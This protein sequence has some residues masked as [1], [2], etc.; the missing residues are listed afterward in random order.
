MSAATELNL[1]LLRSVEK[2][3]ALYDRTDENYRKRLPSENAWDMVASEVGESVEKCKR[4]WRQLRNDYTRWC[5]ADVNR[6]RNGQRRLAYPLADELRFL[7]R[8]LNIADDMAADDDRSVL[9]DKD[10]DNNRDSEGGDHHSQALLKERAS[11]TSKLVKEVKLANQVRKEKSQDKRENFVN[12]GEKQ[13]S[14]RKSAE[15]KLDELEESDEPEK[16]PELDSF[17]QSDNEDDECMDEEHLDDLEGF[18]FDLEQSNQEKEFTPEK[19][20]EKNNTDSTVSRSEFFV[21]QN[22]DPRLLVIGRKNSTASFVE[23][24]A[25]NSNSG[26]PLENAMEDSGDEYGKYGEKRVTGSDTISPSRRLR[27][28]TRASISSA[29]IKDLPIQKPDQEQRV[30]RLQRRIS[31]SLAAVHRVRSSTSP[32]KMTPVPRSQ[33]ISKPPSGQ[34]QIR[35]VSHRD[36]IYPRPEVPA[37]VNIN[38]N[39]IKTQQQ[40]KP[41]IYPKTDAAIANPQGS[42]PPQRR[43]VGRPPKKLPVVQRIVSPETQTKPQS[44]INTKVLTVSKPTSSA[45]SGS[46]HISNIAIK[47][48]IVTSISNSTATTSTIAKGTT[49]NS[50]KT[51]ENVNV[52]SYSPNSST[53]SCSSK[54]NIPTSTTAGT[55]V[56]VGKGMTQ[57]KMAERS[58]QTGVPNPFS[59]NYFLEMI[60]PQMQE[61]NPR[62]KMHFKKKVF[63]A[64]MET[65]DDATDFPTS[66]ELQHFNIN[67]PSGFEHIT[68]PELRLVR[69]LVSMVSAAK[70]TLIRPPGEAT[71]IA[72]ASRSAI[73]PEAQRGA[74]PNVQRQVIQRAYKQGTGQEIV[75]TSPSGGLDKR[76]FRLAP[77][78]GKPNANLSVPQEML[79][80]DS[81]DSIHSAVKVANN[82]PTGSPKGAAIVAAVRPQGSLINKFFGQGNVPTTAKGAAS[83]KAYAISRRYSV[84][85]SSNPPNAQN[86]S[87]GSANGSPINS[88]SSGMDASMLKRR[89]IAPG[90]GMVPP[91]Q[92]PR[93][94]TVAASQVVTASQSGSLLVRKSVGCVPAYQKQISPTG[95]GSLLQKIPQIASVQGSA[96]ND[97]V[98]PKPAATPSVNGEESSPSSALKRSLVVAN[99]KTSFQDLLQQPSQT[100]QRNKI[101][102]SETAATIA[103]DDFSLENLKREPVDSA[104]DHNDILGI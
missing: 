81:V 99:T 9:S 92:R 69:E 15:E 62:Q 30:T 55:S 44:P 39:Q 101:E 37:V 67:T 20:S 2:Q 104:E 103:A 26:D 19:S 7:D 24:K 34:V 95:G 41:V 97:F 21:K 71:A 1:L 65:F 64:L 66:K 80:K 85:G 49:N 46:S 94:S 68:D 63:Q 83:E 61:M 47:S 79:R 27:R 43:S 93:Y 87:Q 78:S 14:R 36:D 4:R 29:G 50:I 11:S 91:T 88:N 98:Q 89:L 60:K 32:V 10:R 90:H 72:T 70:V 31:M 76:L 18:D 102:S 59:D 23:S 53:T 100:L 3:T 48:N 75:P 6:R 84:C 51:T 22:R 17:L 42:A 25:L 96:F 82:A 45:A 58:T 5:N 40:E 86:A 28:K 38:Q 33:P 52:I 54:A 77:I 16:V 12:H 57:L 73:V 74:R 35:E 8:H 56:P 13:R